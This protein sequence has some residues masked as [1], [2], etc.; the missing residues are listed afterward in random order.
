M[1]SE[2]AVIGPKTKLSRI[3]EQLWLAE[4]L[5]LHATAYSVPLFLRIKGPVDEDALT[6]SLLDIVTRHEVLRT[7]IFEEDGELRG[8]VRPATDFTV[9]IRQSSTSDLLNGGGLDAVLAAEAGTPLDVSQGIPLRAKLIRIAD[10]E[11]VLSLVLHHLVFDD[12]SRNQFYRELAERYRKRTTGSRAAPRPLSVQYHQYAVQRDQHNAADREAMLA[13]WRPVLEHLV[14]FE[15]PPD[16]PRATRRRGRGDAV[17]FELAAESVDAIRR[18]G[19]AR[20]ASAAMVLFTAVQVALSR[21]TGRDDVSFGAP[22]AARDDD[23]S[24]ELIGPLINTVVVRGDLSGDPPFV[25]LVDRLRDT[26]LDAM[27]H[28]RMPFGDLAAEFGNVA[29]LS[30]NPLTQVVV[31][32]ASGVRRRPELDGC[33]VTELAAP[34]AGSKFDLVILFDELDDGRLTIRTGWDRDLYA[35]DTIEGFADVLQSVIDDVLLSPQTRLSAIRTFSARAESEVLAQARTW[36]EAIAVVPEGGR[37][38][39]Y[40]ELDSMA[41]R[42]ATQLIG[43]PP[44]NTRVYVLDQWWN[45]VPPGASGELCIG[46]PGIA[47]G[48]LGLPALTAQR[49][50]PDPGA[51]G[52]RLFRTG[53]IVR[54]SSATKSYRFLGRRDPQVGTGGVLAAPADVEGVVASRSAEAEASPVAEVP[55]ERQRGLLEIWREVLGRADV[56]A[57]SNFFTSGGNSLVAIQMTNRARERLAVDVPLSLVFEAPVF[58]DYSARLAEISSWAATGDGIERPA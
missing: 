10:D 16:H 32:Y 8:E 46:G 19:N 6:S 37:L 39:T 4:R 17:D 54:Y 24:Q 12:W 26:L 44:P 7:R 58:S 20:D 52:E 27:E 11:R 48:Y 31:Q 56:V 5:G 29:D 43:S 55:T 45:P 35:V 47:R 2:D 34:T 42:V 50:V 22:V 51:I 13:Y 23:E 18:I 33:E 53:K 14:P 57:T 15:I 36:P 9:E 49:F 21:F 3:Q 25:E 40:M 30:R 1:R 28:S 41:D 38:C